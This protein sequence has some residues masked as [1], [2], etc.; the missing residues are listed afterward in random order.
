MRMSY[1]LLLASL[2]FMLANDD[3]MSQ[4]AFAL[5]I[6]HRARAD[7]KAIGIEEA[8]ASAASN[9]QNVIKAKD[10]LDAAKTDVSDAVPWRGSKL[11]LDATYAEDL[12]PDQVRPATTLPYSAGASL[13]VPILS[14]LS[15]SA[16]AK[17]GGSYSASLSWSP[18][19]ADQDGIKTRYAL[20]KAE[21]A[22]AEAMRQAR[23]DA[24]TSYV[25]VLNAEAQVSA[26]KRSLDKAS[27]DLANAQENHTLGELSKA[28]LAK[29]HAAQPR[30]QAA[31]RKAEAQLASAQSALALRLGGE[32]GAALEAGA[33]LDAS[34]LLSTLDHGW[35]AAEYS[36]GKA[37]LEA[38]LAL[39]QAKEASLWSASGPVSLSG[40]MAVDGTISIRGTIAL[41]W[42]TLAGSSAAKRQL[43]IDGAELDLANA[44]VSEE[45]E[46]LDALLSLEIAELSLIEAQANLELAKSDEAQAFILYRLGEIVSRTLNDAEAA[47][48]KAELDLQLAT[49]ELARSR[50]ALE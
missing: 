40:S 9:A 5:G 36:P 1:A 31:Y 29:A 12:S 46:R 23:L 30:A 41:D 10:A 14:N 11:A 21:L 37:V 47:R 24:L 38:R 26:A 49:I 35:T 25:Q 48:A 4:E 32:L 50:L 15:A 22:Y 43:A 42:K 16:T 19:A 33:P 27:L 20:A 7:I 34:S 45:R 8:M 6:G 3:A 28:A 17:L 18:L 2:L 13:T 44:L 39:E